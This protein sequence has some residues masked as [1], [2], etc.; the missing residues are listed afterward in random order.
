MPCTILLVEDMDDVRELTK[1]VL[2]EHGCRIAG[3][4]S[5]REALEWLSLHDPPCLIFL[6]LLMPE[7][8]GWELADCLVASPEWAD[9]PIV[10]VSASTAVNDRPLQARAVLRKPVTVAQLL[11]ATKHCHL[12]RDARAS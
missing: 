12:H 3:V 11:D 1:A 9:V 5:G 2:E 4:A 10:V 8:N 6:D 7:M